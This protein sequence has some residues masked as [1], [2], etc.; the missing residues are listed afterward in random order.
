MIALRNREFVA[1]GVGEVEAPA[2]RKTEDGQGDLAARFYDVL[3]GLFEI[4]RFDDGERALGSFGGVG[5]EAAFGTAVR[6]GR[7]GWAIFLK[8]P[9]EEVGVEIPACRQVLG[10]QLE[11]N[12]LQIGHSCSHASMCR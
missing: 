11:V 10:W 3:L 6:E 12:D 8:G 9:A 1:C 4:V 2:A 5:V 7:V